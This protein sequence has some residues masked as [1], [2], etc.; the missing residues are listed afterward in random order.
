MQHS[1]ARLPV[2]LTLPP[3]PSPSPSPSHPQLLQVLSK[4]DDWQFDAFKLYEV[5]QGRPLSL[6]SFALLK[7]SEV[8]DK[9][10]LD[11]H[12][13]VKFLMRVEDGYPSNPYHNC[14][15]AADVLQSLHVLVRHGGLIKNG[16]CDEVSLISCYL[17]AVS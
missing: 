17:S 10:Q 15:H 7:R 9:F 4:V 16:F 13:L 14:I 5:S 12:K 6:L 8:V 2:E 1:T 11:E 3:S